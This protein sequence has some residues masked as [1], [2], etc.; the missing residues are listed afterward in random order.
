MTSVL[1]R[2]RA[3]IY[4]GELRRIT[5]IRSMF[6]AVDACFCFIFFQNYRQDF[7]LHHDLLYI[8]SSMGGM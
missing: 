6:S 1:G 8:H 7:C 5:V 4:D 2:I 3:I